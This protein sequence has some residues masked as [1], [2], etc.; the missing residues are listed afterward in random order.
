MESSTTEHASTNA[1]QSSSASSQ[2]KG[3]TMYR[4]EMEILI[5][6]NVPAAYKGTEA[7]ADYW[8]YL[9]SIHGEPLDE[10]DED[11]DPGYASRLRDGIMGYYEVDDD[12]TDN[13]DQ[14]DGEWEDEND[15]R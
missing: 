8:D 11:Y 5:H 7:E 9:V 10:R 2:T 14:E 12:D 6:Q 3:N 4:E 15:S 13:D 1:Q